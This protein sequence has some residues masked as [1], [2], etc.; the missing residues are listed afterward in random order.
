MT[1]LLNL[2]AHESMIDGKSRGIDLTTSQLSILEYDGEWRVAREQDFTDIYGMNLV[3]EGQSIDLMDREKKKEKKDLPPLIY[4][5][6]TGTVTPFTLSLNGPEE[7]VTLAPDARG[8]I[9]ME[10]AP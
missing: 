8:R 3:V 10:A 2:A 1:T 4:F 9:V 6:A 7:S 5:D